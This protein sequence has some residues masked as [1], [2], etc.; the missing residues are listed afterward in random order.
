MLV[1]SPFM[2]PRYTPLSNRQCVHTEAR[3]IFDHTKIESQLDVKFNG[4][5][6]GCI[7]HEDRLRIR[8]S[9]HHRWSDLRR[10]SRL[11]GDLSPVLMALTVLEPFLHQQLWFFKLWRWSESFLKYTLLLL[12]KARKHV[13]WQTNSHMV[14]RQFVLHY[15]SMRWPNDSRRD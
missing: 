9:L 6:R 10:C 3:L 8:S 1:C 2:T 14:A 4:P 11:F 12:P 15:D 7:W 13:R 5:L